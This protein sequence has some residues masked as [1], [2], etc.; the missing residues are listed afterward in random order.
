MVKKITL[1]QIYNVPP[2]NL[3][4]FINPLFNKRFRFLTDEEM[5]DQARSIIRLIAKK[6]PDT[7]LYSDTGAWPLAYICQLFVKTEKLQNQINK[8]RWLPI[9]CPRE[10]FDSYDKVIVS[11]LTPNERLARLS[12][13][14]FKELQ[15]FCKLRSILPPTLD[16]KISREKFILIHKGS[17]NKLF[18]EKINKPLKDTFLSLKQITRT[19]E[20]F[21]LFLGGTKFYRSLFGNVIYLD[22]YVDSGVT[23]SN[24]IN[25][26]KCFNPKI[27]LTTVA[28]HVFAPQKDLNSNVIASVHTK[29]EGAGAFMPGAYPYENRL[30]INGRFYLGRRNNFRRVEISTLRKQ[31]I[32]LNVKNHGT[33]KFLDNCLS[34]IVRN[35]LLEL[36]NT[37]F[38]IKEIIASGVVDERQCIRYLL[39]FFEEGLS[40]SE[41]PSRLLWDLFDMYGP[42][43][44]PLPDSYHFDFWNAVSLVKKEVVEMPEFSV[45]RREY[46]KNRRQVLQEIIHICDKNNRKWKANINKIISNK[47]KKHDRY[48]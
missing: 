7:I 48:K 40:R 28:Y 19:H 46:K 22:E 8:A 16:T 11:L 39:Y 37:K 43:W 23:L 42:A 31:S 29:D 24:T 30:D 47:F 44:S 13:S 21:S 27:K 34:F 45:L 6:N 36:L 14:S 3:E 20:L 17:L 10:A 26:L 9:K 32:N 38:K 4:C 5:V 33:H 35:K 25:V 15:K 1:D 12:Q 2:V 41:I 18:F